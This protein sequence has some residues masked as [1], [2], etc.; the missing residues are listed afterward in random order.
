MSL[1]KKIICDV[2]LALPRYLI[3]ADIFERYHAKREEHRRYGET[4]EIIN[5]YLMQGLQLAV[6]YAP[7][8]LE[9][10]GAYGISIHN[11]DM[12]AGNFALAEVIRANEFAWTKLWREVVSPDPEEEMVR[13]IRGRLA[14]F[15]SFLATFPAYQAVLRE[16]ARRA[17][18]KSN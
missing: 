1:E 6:R 5:S 13:F 4:K 7:L 17:A 10:F 8:V 14:S 12:V 3:G 9:A 15:K 2:A 16:D 18:D 11:P